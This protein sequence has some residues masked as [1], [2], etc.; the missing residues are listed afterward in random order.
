GDTDWL[1]EAR[2]H[3]SRR[4][5]VYAAQLSNGAGKAAKEVNTS[6]LGIRHNF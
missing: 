5:F 1:L 4:T 2:Y 3:L 6:L